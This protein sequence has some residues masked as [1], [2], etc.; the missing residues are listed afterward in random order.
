MNAGKKVRTQLT[1]KSGN[2]INVYG[3]LTEE[4]N[5]VAAWTAS[6]HLGYFR[7]ERFAGST[8]T[9]RTLHDLLTGA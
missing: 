5:Y 1:S 7:I 9:A 4:G 6:Q 2:S 3:Q 8:L